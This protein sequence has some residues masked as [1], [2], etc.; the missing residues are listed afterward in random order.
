[1]CIYKLPVLKSLRLL[2]TYSIQFCET[3]L[4]LSGQITRLLQFLLNSIPK[5]KTQNS[6]PLLTQLSL[7]I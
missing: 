5:T 3:S 4:P 6:Q 2:N 7:K 1:M